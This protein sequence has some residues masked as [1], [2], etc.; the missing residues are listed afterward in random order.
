M[1]TPAATEQRFATHVVDN[2]PPPLAPYD[3]WRTDVP[4]Q[5]ALAREGAA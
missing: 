2:Q 4:L 3:A 1:S 5:Q